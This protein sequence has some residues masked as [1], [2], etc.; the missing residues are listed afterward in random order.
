L[1]TGSWLDPYL[2]VTY[3]QS[4]Q[5]GIEFSD[6]RIKMGLP[7]SMKAQLLDGF[8]RPYSYRD[9][10]LPKIST[11]HDVLIKVEAASFCHTDAVLAAGEF[12][13]YPPSWPVIGSHEFVGTV[14]SIPDEWA[15]E[16]IPPASWKLFRPGDRVAVCCNKYGVCGVCDE[17]RKDTGDDYCDPPGF[18]GHCP[19]GASSGLGRDGGFAQYAVADVRQLVPIPDG[20]TAVDTAPMMC[21]GVTIYSAL[22]K[23]DPSSAS[24]PR[25]GILG[26]GGGLGHLGLLFATKM[27]F[28]EVIGVDAADTAL[29]LSRNLNTGARILDS[30]TDDPEQIRSEIGQKEGKE[31]RSEMG[32]DFVIVLPDSQ[33][34]FDYGSKLLRNHGKMIVVSFPTRGF[35]V[36]AFDLV[37]RD[38]AVVGSLFGS[39]KIAAEMLEFSAANEVRPILK[40]YSLARLN[41][42]VEE[43]N[44]GLGGKLVVDLSLEA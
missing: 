43:Y 11:G 37:F 4:E 44:R 25:V 18:S 42:L 24:N 38:I 28:K 12:P 16:V 8:K 19:K 41:D 30:R 39:R 34:A 33:A 21:A 26:C 17:C 32:L 35:H 2:A 6:S 14:V 22:K 20:L 9:T 7:S 3:H 15:K 1:G 23:C 36:S 5:S 29:N 10:D 40:T 31:H 27:G 13:P